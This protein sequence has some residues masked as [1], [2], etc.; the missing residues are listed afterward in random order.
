M[1]EILIELT[2]LNET[3]NYLSKAY[4]P[5]DSNNTKRNFLKQTYRS[6]SASWHQEEE[7]RDMEIHRLQTALG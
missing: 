4:I 6:L 2:S 3:A 7:E 1:A 5:S